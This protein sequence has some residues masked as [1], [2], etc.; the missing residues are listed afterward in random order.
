M[1]EERTYDVLVI[2][3]G[4]AALSAAIAAVDEGARVAVL[5]KA[6]REERGG[7]SALTEHMR[8]PYNNVEELLP[9]L[10]NPSDRDIEAIRE[11]LP[12]RDQADLW[13]EVMRVTQGQSDPELLEVHVREAYPT[14]L[15]LRS[16]GH[17]WMP[18]YANPLAGNVVS[19]SGGGYGLQ[20]RNFLYLESRN[21]DIYYQAAFRELM[22]DKTGAVIGANV[23]LPEGYQQFSAKATVIACGGFE[24]NA[25][26]R[27]RYL[28]PGW[29]TV[30]M[31]GVPYNTGDGLQAALAIGAMAYGSWSSCHASPQDVNRPWFGLPS[32]QADG[33]GQGDWSRYAYPYSIM[34]NKNGERFV[35]EAD[36]YRALTYAKMGRAILAQPGGVAFQIFDAKARR[37]GLGLE[38]YDR[39]GATGAKADTLEDLAKKLSIDPEGLV[40][41]VREF[42]AAIQHGELNPNPWRGDGKRTAGIP[43][44]KSNYSISIEEPPF[45]G[46]AVCCGITFT[47]GGLKVD[48]KTAQVQHVAGRPIPGLYTAGEMLGGL[49]HWNYA[50]GSGMMA[51]ATFGRIAGTNAAKAALQLV[52]AK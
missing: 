49:W 20:Q 44:R 4:S 47:F 40:R 1:S 18:S 27:A 33:R 9:L 6:P 10:D 12:K 51:G 22:T 24:G 43:I 25:E 42:N 21:V 17:T 36:D 39:V 35:D 29:D 7:N 46:Y 14:V 38:T 37:L 23:L 41:T 32:N 2:G 13:D 8:F 50:S 31:R 52:R 26:M 5:E 45:E 19:M 30:K 15:W 34:V 28:G 11:R 48:P 16:K 3:A